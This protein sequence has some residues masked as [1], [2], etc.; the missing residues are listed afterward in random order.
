MVCFGFSSVNC[1]V[2]KFFLGVFWFVG[3]WFVL[4][5]GFCVGFVFCLFV[6]VSVFLALLLFGVW[7]FGLGFVFW[8]VC[9]VCVGCVGCD[10]L[11]IVP[12]C[13]EDLL[14]RLSA[15]NIWRM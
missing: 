11:M 4:V 14:K 1:E 5:G 15:Q 10:K 3:V 9:L 12:S 6:V 8:F 2:L 13:M 7:F